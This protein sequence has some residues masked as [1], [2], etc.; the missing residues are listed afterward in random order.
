[1][2]E[3]L[4]LLLCWPCALL[5]ISSAENTGVNSPNKTLKECKL[6]YMQIYTMLRIAWRDTVTELP[7]L[8]IRCPVNKRLICMLLQGHDLAFRPG[9]F[10]PF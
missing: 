4:S 9:I 7:N 8:L 1:M 10:P 5:P 6:G 3:K 2:P